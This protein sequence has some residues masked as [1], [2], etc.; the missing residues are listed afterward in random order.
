MFKSHKLLVGAAAGAFALATVAGS[1]YAADMVVLDSKSSN[2]EISSVIDGDQTITLAAGEMVELLGSDG[3][4]R[5]IE[6]PYSGK[7]GADVGDSGAGSQLVAALS[8]LLKD[9]KRS[10][11]SI[12]TIRSGSGALK[13]VSDDVSDPYLVNVDVKGH[14]CITQGPVILQS[15]ADNSAARKLVLQQKGR[16]KKLSGRW[17]SNTERLQMPANFRIRDNAV[18]S[19]ELGGNDAVEITFHVMPAELK[20]PTEQAVWMANN[21]CKAQT[22]AL[23]RSERS[24]Q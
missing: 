9:S 23:L 12:G 5:K 4:T 7:P 22:L 18:Y 8:G 15:N 17:P 16:V 19:I 14:R 21:K 2:F 3:S 6:G 1:A 24:A 13:G 10:S 11:S 20:S